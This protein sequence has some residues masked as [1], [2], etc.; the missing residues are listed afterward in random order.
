MLSASGWQTFSGE[1]QMVNMLG[2]VGHKVCVATTPLYGNKKA[3]IYQ[4]VKEWAGPDL[5]LGLN[6]LSLLYAIIS[7]N[8]LPRSLLKCHFLSE[9]FTDY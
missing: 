4:E 7:F 5:A 6:S 3:A 8:P 1:G 2:F 9:F